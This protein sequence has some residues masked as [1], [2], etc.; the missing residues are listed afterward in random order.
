MQL[1]RY[2]PKLT[3]PWEAEYWGF[4]CPVF[5]LGLWMCVFCVHSS[6]DANLVPLGV[7]LCAVIS[8]PVG[9][10]AWEKLW[11]CK[12]SVLRLGESHP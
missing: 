4:V 2:C 12:N 11:K 9:K 1:Q 7:F 5:F 10:A 8:F 6:R 3:N